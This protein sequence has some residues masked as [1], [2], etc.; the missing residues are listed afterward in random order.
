VLKRAKS[1]LI[2]VLIKGILG[3]IVT[4]IL[5]VSLAEIEFS[6]WVF[7]LSLNLLI[8]LSDLGL[9]QYIVVDMVQKKD[10]VEDFSEIL[11][12]QDITHLLG[13]YGVL[14]TIVALMIIA[15]SFLYFN[16][17]FKETV[18]N[19]QDSILF[20][21]PM[22]LVAV[23]MFF[24]PILALINVE[25][26]YDER[27]KFEALS[28]FM[29]FIFCVV[30]AKFSWSL[31]IYLA[32]FQCLLLYPSIY[33][34]VELRRRGLSADYFVTPMSI[35]F[36]WTRSV[37]G[38][39]Y[40]YF[41]VNISSYFT[42]MGI[43]VVLGISLS[44]QDLLYVSMGT[45][46]FFQGGF[47]L[48]DLLV[49]LMQPKFRDYLNVGVKLRFY[50]AATVLALLILCASKIISL[51]YADFYFDSMIFFFL[52]IIFIVESG[53]YLSTSLS[54][55]NEK[56][57]KKIALFTFGRALTLVC[58]SFYLSFA[59]FCVAVIF[60]GIVYLIISGASY[61]K[62]ALHL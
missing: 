46:L 16:L 36:K 19:Y 56:N 13:M 6:I 44:K 20:V 25:G 28:Y 24:I 53:I 18:F 62:E 40:S 54:L 11:S 43:P 29:F 26:R 5:S 27:K 37:V 22:V 15:P 51:Y 23:R 57:A 14:Y 45:V 7:F 34:F 61:E 38:K 48:I 1:G 31:F 60:T 9:G 33:F 17:V 10:Q 50:S 49:K 32:I 3:V 41:L 35:S 47:Q 12:D 8:T 58:S 4:M 21:V 39:T 30:G 2:S 59:M 52:S 42:R 55:M